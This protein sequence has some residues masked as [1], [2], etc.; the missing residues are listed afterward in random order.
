MGVIR[1]MRRQKAVYWPKIENDRFG[2]P[3]LGDPVEVDCRW[4]DLAEEFLDGA[5]RKVLSHSKV[6]VDRVVTLGGM[7]WRGLLADAD[8]VALNNAGAHEIRKFDQVPN[9][10]ATETLYRAML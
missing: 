4:V 9:F 2:K 6:Y 7:L 1:R 3:V 8:P 10:K 5:G